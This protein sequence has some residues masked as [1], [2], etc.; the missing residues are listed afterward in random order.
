MTA[1]EINAALG[2]DYT[3]LQVAVAVKLISGAGT[4]TVKRRISTGG[5]NTEKD[6]CKLG[7]LLPHRPFLGKAEE[8]QLPQSL[9]RE[10]FLL[11]NALDL[12]LLKYC[13]CPGTASCSGGRRS[14]SL[15]KRNPHKLLS[16]R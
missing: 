9:L 11:R 13:A 14:S 12:G 6:Y 7:N 5:V 4:T 1:A 10:A 8:S 2:T 15:D 3:A 16:S